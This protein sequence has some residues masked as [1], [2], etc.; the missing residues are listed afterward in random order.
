MCFGLWQKKN[1]SKHEVSLRN[2]SSG[3]KEGGGGA[4]ALEGGGEK[5]KA[6]FSVLPYLLPWARFWSTCTRLWPPSV[7]QPARS[8]APICVGGKD[9]IQELLRITKSTLGSIS[10]THIWWAEKNKQKSFTFSCMYIYVC[11]LILKYLYIINISYKKLNIYIYKVLKTT[12]YLKWNM[13]LN[14]K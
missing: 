5:R 4:K 10:I 6:S 7:L 8:T 12:G 2:S 14:H 9:E 1:G 11:I 3:H 13:H